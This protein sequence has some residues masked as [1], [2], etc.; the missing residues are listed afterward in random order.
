MKYKVFYIAIILSTL[1]FMLSLVACQ[2]SAPP[3]ISAEEKHEAPVQLDLT[4]LCENLS[5]EMQEVDNTRTT[6][7]LEQIN[8]DLKICIPLVDLKQQ[9]HLMHLSNQMYNN[10]LTV[11]RTSK[12]QK[13][14]E[15]HALN[16]AQYPTVQQSHH[17]EFSLRDQY[18]LKHKGQ[19]YVE[20]HENTQQNLVYRRNPQYLARI[21]AP[22]LPQ[23]ER[24]FI[25][26]LAQQNMQNL[27]Y[28]QDITIDANELLERALFWEDY[29]NKYP[30][31]QFIKEAQYLYQAYSQLLFKGVSVN[32]VSESYLGESSIKSDHLSAIE[33]LSKLNKSQLSNQAR[34]F[35]S[36]IQMNLNERTKL[37]GFEHPSAQLNQY[38]KLKSVQLNQP[39]DCFSDAICYKN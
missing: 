30:K 37:T 33:K 25:E 20:L 8:H 24:V 6:F 11:K 18:L 38:L 29:V 5:K 34:R 39:F 4:H 1:G 7:A 35:L 17:Q 14:F 15:S 32:P 22:Y 31:S 21:F 28:N 19:A 12:E 10:F 13:A 16:M 9:M 2:K 27:F 3:P 26:N 36:F 23:A